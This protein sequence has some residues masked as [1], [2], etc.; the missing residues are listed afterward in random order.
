MELFGPIR[1]QPH[2]SELASVKALY[3]GAAPID[4]TGRTEFEAARNISLNPFHAHPLPRST[5]KTVAAECSIISSLSAGCTPSQKV[6]FI[7]RSE[8]S[9]V[10]LTL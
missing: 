7:T 4:E 6:S 9:S 1:P 5:S 2:L 3:E 8:F 10:P